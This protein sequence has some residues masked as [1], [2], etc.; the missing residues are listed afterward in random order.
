M[1]PSELA[2]VN[3]P[4]FDLVVV[5]PLE[6][7]VEEFTAIF[8]LLEDHSTESTFR[9]TVDGGHP[10]ISILMIQQDGMGKTHARQAASAALND[11]DAG[12]AICLGIGGCLTDDLCLGDVCYSNNVF[13]VLDNAKV[14]DVGDKGLNM[15][16]S[17]T[18]FVTDR[19]L[20]AALGFM[21]QKK[22]LKPR[23]QQWQAEREAFAKSLSI[24]IVT[25]RNGRQET[26]GAP[27]T[28]DGSIACASVTKSDEYNDRLKRIDRKVLA[29]ETESAGVYEA[30]KANEV[31]AITIRGI[32]DHADDSKNKLESGTS[33]AI[34]KVAAANA[35]SF[36]QLQLGNPEFRNFLNGRRRTVQGGSVELQTG[37]ASSTRPL[38]EVVADAATAIDDKLREL[39]PEFKLQP[40]GYRLPVPRVRHIQ[41]NN[42]IGE[43]SRG[44]PITLAEAF[45][46]RT[47]LLLRLPR[48]YPDYSL[49]WVIAND[50]L[51]TEIDGKQAMPVVIDGALM[52]APRA[53]FSALAMHSVADIDPSDAVQVIYIVDNVPSGSKSRLSFLESE[54]A[55]EPDAKFLFISRDDAQMVELTEFANQQRA[56]TFEICSISFLEIA[57]FVQKNFSM[58]GSEAEVVALRLRD[59]FEQFDL[60]AHPTYFAGIPK[61]VLSAAFAGQQAI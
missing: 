26:L 51:A 50:M 56:D 29:V 2:T 30:A 5:I 9:F 40:K 3:R 11:F 8:G 32:S 37:L 47:A 14:S 13:D 21:R 15:D 23:Y 27:R 46:T 6:E 42:A 39:C 34:R 28:K 43:A 17:P 10:D 61:E 22:D 45:E 20:T 12:V 38:L 19:K 53:G 48:T 25:G 24:G 16:F 36:L 57:H 33:G 49:P 60:S 59:T 41:L 7:E 35:A 54:I 1:V 58:S 4:Y 18:H 31:P 55:C 44:S 52:R